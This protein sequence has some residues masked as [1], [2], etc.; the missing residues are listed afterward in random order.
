MQVTVRLGKRRLCIKV[1][2]LQVLTPT[3]LKGAGQLLCSLL[4]VGC[5]VKLHK[6]IHLKQLCL[7]E[8]MRCNHLPTPRRDPHMGG[9]R[10]AGPGDFQGTERSIMPLR[11]DM[12]PGGT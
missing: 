2:V 6:L 7:H 9:K 8:P 11:D 3:V 12:V 5:F 4:S 1:C 10:Q